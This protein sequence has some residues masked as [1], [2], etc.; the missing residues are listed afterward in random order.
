MVLKLQCLVRGKLGRIKWAKKRWNIAAG[1]IQ[2]LWRGVVARSQCD[3]L[4][5]DKTVVPIQKMA[6]KATARQRVQ[7]VRV[8]MNEAAMVIQKKVRSRQSCQK[9]TE[10]LLKREI[11]YRLDS[12]AMITSEEEYWQEKIAKVVTRLMQ[13]DLRAKAESASLNYH[14][15]LLDVYNAENDYVEMMRQKEILSPR[16]IVQGYFQELNRNCIDLRDKLTN[17]KQEVLFKRLMHHLHVDAVLEHQVDVVVDMAKQRDRLVQY[18]EMENAE[19]V[20]RTQERDLLERTNRKR[21]AIAAERRRWAVR[22]TT[23][24]GKPDKTRRPG[25]P[26][27]KKIVAGPDKQTYTGTGINMF[28]EMG[29]ENLRPGETGSVEQTLQRMS[30]QTY[31]EEVNAYEQILN[32]L[33]GAMK[34]MY[35]GPP[36]EVQ[37]DELGFGPEGKKLAPA[38]WQIGK[39]L[40]FENVLSHFCASITLPTNKH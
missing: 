33:M 22:Y 37:P 36:G 27:D 25:R 9:L 38:L 2:A 40:F 39:W 12:V 11:E 10:K 13:K 31:L 26:W 23:R 34:G 6:R 16:A 20:E 35:G 8:E 19:K 1:R 32:P 17:L 14:Q 30:L 24:N 15:G 18:R 7:A 21:E 28:A 5:L 3:K 4:W 29:R